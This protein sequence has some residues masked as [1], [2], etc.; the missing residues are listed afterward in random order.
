MAGRMAGKTALISGAASGLGDAQAKLFA[1]QG[2]RRALGDLQEATGQQGLRVN[3]TFPGQ[4]RTPILGDITP[5]QD[6]A[7]QAAIPMGGGGDLMDGAYGALFLAA[8]AARYVTGAKVWIVGGWYA[9][10]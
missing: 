7:I 4:I 8:E 6:A 2:A 5:G 10:H 9:S 3:A 1:Q